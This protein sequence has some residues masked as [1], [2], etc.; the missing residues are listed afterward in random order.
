MHRSRSG[1]AVPWALEEGLP[2]GSERRSANA[3]GCAQAAAES[4]ANRHVARP[5]DFAS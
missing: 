5:A 4:R 3:R 1:F 2:L